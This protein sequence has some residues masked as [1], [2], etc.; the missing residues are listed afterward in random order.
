MSGIGIRNLV[1]RGTEYTSK[2]IDQFIISSTNI[3]NSIKQYKYKDDD[4]KTTDSV[5]RR[6]MMIALIRDTY[7]CNLLLGYSAMMRLI[8]DDQIFEK[9]DTKLMKYIDE[10]YND[11]EFKKS[12]CKIYTKYKGEYS[13]IELGDNINYENLEFIRFLERIIDRL[14]II[15]RKAT[16]QSHITMLENKIYNLINVTPLIT[17][18]IMHIKSIPT[19]KLQK[20][21]ITGKKNTKNNTEIVEIPL[22]YDNYSIL[23]NNVKSL[24]IRHEIEKKYVSRSHTSMK[25]FADLVVYRKLF[26]TEM[27]YPSFFQYVTRD[28]KDNSEIIKK[29]IISL[30]SKI[31]HQTEVEINKIHNYYNKRLDVPNHKKITHGDISRYI[32]IHSNTRTYDKYVVLYYLFLLIK[33]YF[34]ITV[35]RYD[36]QTEDNINNTNNIN[37]DDFKGFEFVLD[38]DNNTDNNDNSESRL[39]GRLYIDIDKSE[40]KKIMDP[41]SIKVS[42]R[43]LISNNVYTVPEVVLLANYDKEITYLEV[44]QLFKEFGYILQELCYKSGVGLVN[45]DPEFSNFLPLLMENIAWDRDTVELI[46]GN[47]NSDIVDH[48]FA[49]RYFNICIALKQKCIN[50][51]FDHLLH[52][53]DEMI[54]ILIQIINDN[55]TDEQLSDSIRNTIVQLYQ[56]IYKES[57]DCVSDY[58]DIPDDISFTSIDPLALVQEINGSQGLLYSNLMNEVFAYAT[59]YILK[60]KLKN[61]TEF[62]QVVL[63]NG[64]TPFKDLISE[65]MDIP[66]LNSFNLYLTKLLGVT[67]KIQNQN[68]MMHL[69]NQ[70]ADQEANQESNQESND[71]ILTDDYI[72]TEYDSSYNNFDDRVYIATDTEPDKGSIIRINRI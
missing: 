11:D 70:E 31:E 23:M 33:K 14:Q 53:S 19:D 22:H 2:F 45:R 34:G 28:K 5:E 43:M 4:D 49:M 12:L 68:D 1:N 38:P 65:F 7:V 40:T 24:N 58:V 50:A 46:C 37:F 30:N 54:E 60:N 57:F 15:D 18:D 21:E 52:N 66:N 71:Y 72:N 27:G 69:S 25:D 42:D 9:M 6:N 20:I 29:L 35:K 3:K 48:T 59:F 55:Q 26:A 64:V 17:L 16:I 36:Y 39:L 13:N 44:V 10:F 56:T 32:K 51:K 67:D 41:I 47:K 62:R 8:T 61:G 63:E